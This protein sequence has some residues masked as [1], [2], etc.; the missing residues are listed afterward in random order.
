MNRRTFVQAAGAQ[1]GAAVLSAA[2]Q[3]KPIDRKGRIKQSVCRWCYSKIP[4]EDFARE[5]ARLGLKSVDLAQPAE[6]PVIKKY[7]L[8]PTMIGGGTTIPDGFNRKENHE[9]IEQRFRESVRNAVEFGAP[10]IIVFSGNRKGMSDEEGLENCLIGLKKV[11]PMAE[12][13]GL[14]VCMELLNSKV[15]HKDYMCDYT[16]WG[17]ELAKR[18]GSPQFKLLYDIYHMQIME[19][20][21]IRTLRD[22]AQY[23][24]HLHTGG[25]PGRNEIDETQE[26]NYKAIT[27]AAIEMGFTGYMAH[28]FIP[29]RD[30]LT[31]LAE[32]VELCDV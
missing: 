26:L 21:V 23:I 16:K 6:W 27:R 30:P 25:N 2:S 1:A 29:K 10:S 32:A 11:M 9:G 28:E 14:L 8:I 12:D 15:N 31:S 24:G 7:N 19:G 5:C 13:K 3:V 18:V 17:V 4:I 22:N 20:D